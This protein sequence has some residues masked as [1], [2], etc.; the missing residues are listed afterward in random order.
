MY[1]VQCGFC[2]VARVSQAPNVVNTAYNICVPVAMVLVA[3]DPNI[4]LSKVLSN[5]NIHVSGQGTQ[6]SS[7]QLADFR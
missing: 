2:H 5:T 4:R 7:H 3:I 6:P 1:H